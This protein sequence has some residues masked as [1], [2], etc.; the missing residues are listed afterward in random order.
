[1]LFLD[2]NKNTITHVSLSSIDKWSPYGARVLSC[3]AE[4]EFS[5]IL[6]INIQY[7]LNYSVLPKS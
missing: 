7:H 3:E 1:M 6:C 2:G 4:T 5:Y